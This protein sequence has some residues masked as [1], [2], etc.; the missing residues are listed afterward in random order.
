MERQIISK[1]ING[2]LVE[3][4]R[5]SGALR[6]LES[7]NPCEQSTDYAQLSIDAATLGE[8]VTCRLRHIIYANALAPK[9][10]YLQQAAD[11]QGIKIEQRDGIIEVTLPG[12]LPK[13]KRRASSEFLLDPLLFAMIEYAETHDI[14][15][16]RDCV[17]CFSNVYSRELPTRRIRDYDNLE[18]KQILDVIAGFVMTDD[19][20]RLCDVFNTTELG[21]VDCTRITLMHKN[22]FVEW[23]R[24]RAEALEAASNLD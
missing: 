1:R 11:A 23:V 3:I 5:L 14:P 15:R 18:Q 20:G 16:Y 6:V 2:I 19:S 17:V 24:E 12:L 7:A 21:D 13:R 10:E 22:R 4:S 8:R 9:A